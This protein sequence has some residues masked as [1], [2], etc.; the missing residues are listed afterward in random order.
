MDE[1]DCERGTVVTLDEAST[2]E[3]EGREMEIVPAWQWL[4]T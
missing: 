1:L 4:L 3:H 2:V